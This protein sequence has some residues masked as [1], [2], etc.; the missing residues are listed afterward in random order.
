MAGNDEIRNIINDFLNNASPEELLEFKSLLE[1]RGDRRSVLG[2]INLQGIADNLASDL[3]KRMGLTTEKV[4]QLARNIV[5]DMI[6]QYDPHIPEG[7]LQML[8]DH[9]T[10]DRG[11]ARK[12]LPADMMVTMISQ[13][14]AFGRG[15]LSEEDLK[16][17]PDGWYEKYWANFPVDLQKLIRAYIKDE[18]GKEKFWNAV[19]AF[20]LQ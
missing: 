4:S 14:V 15:E 18:I 6:L 3:Q 2:G 8:L 16:E 7:D 13:F 17:Y 19:E 1:K 12:K 11:H 20:L 10:P 5:R 9:W